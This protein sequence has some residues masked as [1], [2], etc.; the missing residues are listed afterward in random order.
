MNSFKKGDPVCVVGNI[1]TIKTCIGLFGYVTE[2]Y[3]NGELYLSLLSKPTL[4]DPADKL[5]E[6]HGR[7]KTWGARAQPHNLQPLKDKDCLARVAALKEFVATNVRDP[8]TAELVNSIIKKTSTPE[9][10]EKRKQ[11]E[12]EIAEET[13][14]IG[15]VFT[16]PGDIKRGD[17][18]NF[19]AYHDP[20]VEAISA[21]LMRYAYVGPSKCTLTERARWKQCLQATDMAS[22]WSGEQ[23]VR[24]VVKEFDL[25]PMTDGYEYALWRKCSNE[26]AKAGELRTLII[27]LWNKGANIHKIIDMEDKDTCWASYKSSKP[28]GFLVYYGFRRKLPMPPKNIKSN[29]DPRGNR[30]TRGSAQAPK[31]ST[32]KLPA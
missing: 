6:T 30:K 15:Q 22:F 10:V 18:S 13:K 16:L 25:D 21:E 32:G 19:P 14:R 12:V 24:D 26:Y 31:G 4:E 2:V 1:C 7:F 8:K 27:K 29:E 9:W 5:E 28:A 23:E 17:K 20:V 3:E 11:E